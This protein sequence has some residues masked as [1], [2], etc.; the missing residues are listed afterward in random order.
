MDISIGELI[1][2]A[3]LFWVASQII[4]GIIDAFQIV[5]LSE[6]VALLKHLGDII[7]QVRIEV[8]NGIEY[9]YDADKGAFL[10]QGST[11]EEVAEVLK[12]RFPEHVFLIDGRG[13]IAAQTN[14]QLMTPEEFKKIKLSTNL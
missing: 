4:L 5:H 10:G 6:R 1:L 2:W 14:W 8:H 13:G 9:W 7:H 11:V 3:V 12:S